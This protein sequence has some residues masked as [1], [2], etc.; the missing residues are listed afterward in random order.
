MEKVMDKKIT[1]VQVIDELGRIRIPFEIRK[2]LQLHTREK[3][4]IYTSGK[5]I[6]LKKRVNEKSNKLNNANIILR[7]IDEF[8]RLVLPIEI[9]KEQ[10]FK[11][12]DQVKFC[13]K[14]DYIILIKTNN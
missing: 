4:E 1:K 3:L 13:V 8:G 10:N 11:E 5:N 6:I 12:N 2:R 14:D 9:R 7:V